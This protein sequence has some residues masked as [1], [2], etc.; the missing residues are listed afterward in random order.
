MI[1]R[2]ILQIGSLDSGVPIDYGVSVLDCE[3]TYPGF[4]TSKEWYASSTKSLSSWLGGKADATLQLGDLT[5]VKQ[6]LVNVLRFRLR[7][8]EED[9]FGKLVGHLPGGRTGSLG[10][11]P[12]GL[13][14]QS[15]LG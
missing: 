6:W 5:P 13:A 12:T 1:E 2:L 9:N 14:Q 10:I 3:G 4:S 11:D 7:I 8:L 15:H